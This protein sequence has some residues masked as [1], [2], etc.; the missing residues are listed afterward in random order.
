MTRSLIN[1]RSNSNYPDIRDYTSSAYEYGGNDSTRSSFSEEESPL[2]TVGFVQ[3]STSSASQSTIVDPNISQSDV[4]PPNIEHRLSRESN[5]SSVNHVTGWNL[6]RRLDFHL[7]LWPFILISTSSSIFSFNVDEILEKFAQVDQTIVD[8]DLKIVIFL[9]ILAPV[10]IGYF[11]DK[12]YNSLPRVNICIFSLIPCCLCSLFLFIFPKVAFV[13]N[14]T[15]FCVV[16]AQI[17]CWTC[18]PGIIKE[19]FGSRF[20]AVNLTIILTAWCLFFAL[21]NI[22]FQNTVVYGDESSFKIWLV[23]F[24]ICFIFSLTMW[25]VYAKNN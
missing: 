9:Q 18:V 14:S 12:M 23:F 17:G 10:L 5:Q 22:F 15:L 13:Y 24:D 7:L 4:V 21:L 25:I 8:E 6:I 19:K 3:P 16:F 1:E 2:P 11:S 20:F